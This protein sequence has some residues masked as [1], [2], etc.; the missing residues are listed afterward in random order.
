MNFWRTLFFLAGIS[1]IGAS[2]QTNTMKTSTPIVSPVDL[3]IPV[4]NP[5]LV[6]AI[7]QHQSAQSNDTAVELFRELKVSVLL[8]GVILD[9][10]PVKTSESQALFKKGDKIGFIEVR[11]KNDKKLLALFT[12]QD[13]L[14]HFT[15]KANSTFVMPTKQAMNFVLEKNYDGLVVNPAGTAS[16]RLDTPFIRTVVGDM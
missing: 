14:Q 9:N 8:A 13:E 12:D 4:T 2:A 10:A 3:N 5:Y 15:N 11:D 7:Q 6:A 16:L 1:A